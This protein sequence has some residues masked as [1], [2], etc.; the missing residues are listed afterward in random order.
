[1]KTSLT[2]PKDAMS[3]TPTSSQELNA[4]RDRATLVAL[5]VMLRTLCT[6]IAAQSPE[7]AKALRSTFVG[8]RKTHASLVLKE[9]GA[10]GS[11]MV[12]SEYQNLMEELLSFVEKGLPEGK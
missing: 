10:V 9:L 5:K 12:T 6:V 3:L 4:F 2:T 11:D 8:L 7:Q 1:M